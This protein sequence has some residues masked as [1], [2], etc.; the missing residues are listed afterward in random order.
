MGQLDPEQIRSS[1]DRSSLL[2][3]LG[4]KERLELRQRCEPIDI[5]HGDAF[6]VCSDG[7]WERV[8]EREMEADLLKSHSS[9]EWLRLMLKRHLLLSGGSGDNFTAVCG[10]FADCPVQEKKPPKRRVNLRLII[11]AAVA[12]LMLCALAAALFFLSGGTDNDPK[13]PKNPTSQQN[14]IN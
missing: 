10:I 12:A 2:K 4:N 1:E 14:R 11:A 5:R 13:A 8:H 7:F 9:A 6:L 3:A